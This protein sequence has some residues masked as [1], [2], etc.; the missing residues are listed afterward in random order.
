MEILT[1]LIEQWPL[2][3]FSFLKSCG[4]SESPLRRH[5]EVAVFSI[6]DEL[7]YYLKKGQNANIL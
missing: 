5:K 2:Q 3:I 4:S 1:Y 7:F 6:Q